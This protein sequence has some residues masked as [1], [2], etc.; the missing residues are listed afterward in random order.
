M[1]GSVMK[2]K[3]ATKVADDM[4]ADYVFDYSTG[5]RGKYP[6]RVTTEATNIVVLEPDVARAFR[7]SAAVNDAL[8]SLLQISETTRR[9]T[10]RSNAKSRKPRGKTS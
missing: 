8:R 2:R 10:T 3:R 4:R 6:R 7:S 5:I 9:L 1:R